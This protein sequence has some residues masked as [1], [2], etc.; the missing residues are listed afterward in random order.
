MS[1][2]YIKALAAQQGCKKITVACFN[3]KTWNNQLNVK[4]LEKLT[5]LSEI[6][7]LHS[8][9]KFST[10]LDKKF[11]NVEKNRILYIKFFILLGPYI[12]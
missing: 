12:S 1:Y 7:K 2:M 5:E 3:I 8:V 11:V 6:L 4:N 9:L 10:S